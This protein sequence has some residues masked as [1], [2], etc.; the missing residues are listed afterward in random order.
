[1]TVYRI[2]KYIVLSYSNVCLFFCHAFTPNLQKQSALD[3]VHTWDND[4]CF[5]EKQELKSSKNVILLEIAYKMR[6]FIILKNIGF[7]LEKYSNLIF[8]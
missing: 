4:I 6:D 2:L 1:M 5:K 3:F 8:G 7:H